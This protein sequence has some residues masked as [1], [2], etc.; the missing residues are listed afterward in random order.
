MASYRCTAC[1]SFLILE[2]L[3]CPRCGVAVGFHRPS[4]TFAVLADDL[5]VVIDGEEFH[6][7]SQ[8]GWQCNWLVG[9]SE[10]SGR[11]FSCRLTRRAPAL[12][13][14]IALEKLADTKIAKRRLLVQLFQ[15]GLP[16]TPY[17]EKEGGLAFDLLSS[18]STGERVT[19]GHANGVITIDLAETLDAHRE[20][21]R[22]QLGEPY[23]TMLG[24]LRHEVGHYYQNVL[25]SDWDECRALFGDE[26]ASYRDAIDRHYRTGAPDDWR[27]SFI[28]E[29]ATMHP[30]EDFAECF[31]HYLHITGTLHTSA[32][33][34]LELVASHA[35]EVMASVVPRLDYA[36]ADMRTVLDDWDLIATFF[37]QVNRSMGHRP[38]YPFV[39]NDVVAT[40]LTYIHRLITGHA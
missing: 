35:E 16:V 14:T 19:I 15:L 1:G 37:N 28:S 17:H 10:R 9:E 8:R 36:D 31:A 24:H 27:E 33:A 20:R 2:S 38:L 11:C 6:A 25:V 7:C 12:D 18:R 26:R 39:I 5:A 23:R 40:K 21:L 32:R 29:Y 13:D 4:L 22:V 30:W 3:T 34:G